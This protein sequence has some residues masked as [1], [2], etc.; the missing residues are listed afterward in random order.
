M[1]RVDC[2]DTFIAV[3]GDCAVRRGTPPP[4]REDNPSV[5]ARAYQMIADHPYEYTS[6]DV[7]FSVYADR[8]GIPERDRPAAR[9]RFY[10]RGQ[11]CLRSSDLGKRYGWGIHADAHG[12]IAL[13]GVDTPEYARFAQGDDVTVTR[14]MNSRRT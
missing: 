9:A 10:S 11:A 1:E 7:I 6:A 2:V 13:Y 14:A 4:V 5:A 3:A 8:N 12:R